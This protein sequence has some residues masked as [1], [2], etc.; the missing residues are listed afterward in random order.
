M[1]FE[2]FGSTYRWEHILILVATL[3]AVY[4]LWGIGTWIAQQ[5]RKSSKSQLVTEIGESTTKTPRSAHIHATESSPA[6]RHKLRRTLAWLIAHFSFQGIATRKQFILTQI[7]TGIV[8]GLVFIICLSM[9]ESWNIF[10]QRL[11]VIILLLGIGVAF[12]LNWAVSTRRTS[13]LRLT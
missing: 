3:L 8:L 7:T 6:A 5:V 9:F 10:I 12:W 2:F 4:V 1:T 13:V 11:G